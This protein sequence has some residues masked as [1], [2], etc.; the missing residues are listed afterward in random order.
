MTTL[1]RRV[2]RD[3]TAAGYTPGKAACGGTCRARDM[4]RKE[5]VGTGDVGAVVAPVDGGVVGSDVF[6][7]GALI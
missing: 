3:A 4:G 1:C 5:R 2:Q 7:W 6:I